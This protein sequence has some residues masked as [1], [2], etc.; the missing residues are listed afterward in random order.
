[1]D[2]DVLLK[3]EFCLLRFQTSLVRDSLK[4][5]VLLFRR[6]AH[7]PTEL[8]HGLGERNCCLLIFSY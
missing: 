5:L 2:A 1:M 8:L 7:S 3:G 6:G 4:A